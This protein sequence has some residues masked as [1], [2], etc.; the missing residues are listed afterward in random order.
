MFG[1]R[2]I[3]KR[4]HQLEL[5]EA[6]QKGASHEHA[7]SRESFFGRARAYDEAANYLQSAIIKAIED[8]GL[9]YFEHETGTYEIQPKKVKR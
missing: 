5:V 4:K 7:R 8:G 2:L 9:V 6:Y 3:R 1:W